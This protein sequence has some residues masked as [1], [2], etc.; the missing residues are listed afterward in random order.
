[1]KKGEEGIVLEGAQFRTIRWGEMGI[2]F[3]KKT[4]RNE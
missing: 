1:M 2:R 4:K 3:G